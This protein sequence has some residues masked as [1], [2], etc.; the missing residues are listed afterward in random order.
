[1]L[2]GFGTNDSITTLP[3]IIYGDNS[4][5]IELTRKRA[6][7]INRTKHWQMQWNWLH[8]HREMNTFVP[9]KIGTYEMLADIFTKPMVNTTH[10]RFVKALRLDNT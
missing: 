1:M 9:E 8:E 4:A 3:T 2:D 7:S 6:E 10:H 5:C